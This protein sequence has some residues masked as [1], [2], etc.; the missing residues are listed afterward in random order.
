MRRRRRTGC[1]GRMVSASG[2]PTTRSWVQVPCKQVD[3]STTILRG[4]VYVLGL[5]MVH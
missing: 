1:N 3:S 4:L 5:S 2:L